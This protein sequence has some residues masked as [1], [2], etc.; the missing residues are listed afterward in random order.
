MIVLTVLFSV[1]MPSNCYRAMIAIM[2]LTNLDII[3][4]EAFLNSIFTFSAESGPLNP[5][6]EEAG[7]DSSNFIIELG[8]LFLIICGSVAFYITRYFL[9]RSLRNC[10]DN[11]I[12]RRL[13]KRLM[14]IA[15]I[16][17]FLIE[18]CIELGLV[19]MIATRKISYERFEYV[20]D[21]TAAVFGIM[22][23]AC[24]GI[25]PFYLLYVGNK[26]TKN[27]SEL[28]DRQKASYNALFEA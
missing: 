14:L 27:A 18:G 20:Q 11:F 12:T 25:A 23:L 4:I 19:A 24:L 22:M 2:K 13:R 3:D 21:G 1:H 9:V 16:V 5:V 7:Y 15:I 26:L 8:P 28:T 10:G 6:F 17:R